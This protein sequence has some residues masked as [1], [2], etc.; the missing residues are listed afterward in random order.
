MTPNPPPTPPG[1]DDFDSSVAGEEDPGAALD[2]AEAEPTP[3]PL[4]PSTDGPSGNRAGRH[5][6]T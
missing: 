4:T 1:E 3:A 2:V 5:T 6:P